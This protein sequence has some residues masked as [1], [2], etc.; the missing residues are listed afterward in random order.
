M[1][2][3]FAGRRTTAVS[4]VGA[5]RHGRVS[6]PRD[7]NIAVLRAMFASRCL[8]ATSKALTIQHCEGIDTITHRSYS[9]SPSS[10]AAWFSCG[11]AV[12]CCAAAGVPALEVFCET[13]CGLFVSMDST[14]VVG[15]ASVESSRDSR[16]DA[17]DLFLVKNVRSGLT[18][19][20][21]DASLALNTAEQNLVTSARPG[22]RSYSAEWRTPGCGSALGPA[23]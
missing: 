6:R 14:T 21:L 3:H 5:S 9:E 23:R 7:A 16:Q 18:S 1:Q 15:T 11:C 22:E 20:A 4:R 19:S 12:G 10:I 8:R 13:L 2:T 17:G